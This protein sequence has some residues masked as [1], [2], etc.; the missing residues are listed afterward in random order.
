M[1]VLELGG[2]VVVV[3]MMMLVLVLMLLMV[4]TVLKFSVDEIV[5]MFESMA[6]M[7][8]L[9]LETFDQQIALKT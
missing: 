4:W 5:L 8:L 6:M 7:V 3:V 1:C 2:L 9:M